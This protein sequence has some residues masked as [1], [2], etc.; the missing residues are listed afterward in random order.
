LT[1]CRRGPKGMRLQTG[2]SNV[3]RKRHQIS[4]SIQVKLEEARL[5]RLV[6]L[7]AECGPRIE[8][9]CFAYAGDVFD[10]A[11][12][13]IEACCTGK[14]RTVA[15]RQSIARATLVID[16]HDERLVA[17]LVYSRPRKGEAGLELGTQGMRQGD[18]PAES[19]LS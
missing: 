5:A 12:P 17:T 19:N 15:K 1:T 2:G 10:R 3:R 13:E 18:L 11:I 6:T 4:D 14:S 9:V 8:P 16:R 7:D